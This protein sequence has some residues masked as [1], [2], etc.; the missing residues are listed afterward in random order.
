MAKKIVI[1]KKKKKQAPQRSVQREVTILGKLLRAAGSAGG[2]MLGGMMG[3]PTLGAAAGNTLGASLSRWLGSGDY[4]VQSNSIVNRTMK[5]SASVPM[6]HRTDQSV[7]IRHREFIQTVDGGTAFGIRANL[8][9][10]PGL[11]VTFPW[12]SQI[13]ANFQEYKFHGLVF[14]YVPTS[15]AATGADTRLGAVMAQTVYRATD[16]VPSTK[17]ELLN[18]FWSNESLPSEA[19]A[20]PIECKASETVLTNRYVRTGAVSDDLM[21]YD[22]G[23]TTFA[24]QGQI[25]AGLIGDLW[26]TY[27]VELRKP[28]LLSTMGQAVKSALFNNTGATMVRPMTNSATEFDSFTGGVT[29]DNPADNDLR[30]QIPRGNAGVI[31]FDITV[32]GTTLGSSGTPGYALTNCTALVNALET[33]TVPT[34]VSSLTRVTLSGCV[35]VTDPTA[36]VIIRVV[37][38][39]WSGALGR[40]VTRVTQ[41]DADV[42]GW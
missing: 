5:G 4:T 18:E 17:Y 8:P 9:L 42:V 36:A 38:Q 10:N 13:A 35:R 33:T 19:M 34:V 22:Y 7:V 27:E 39:T 15:G 3:S 32:S 26:V 31:Y 28:K 29:V 24:T 12:L 14:H 11:A 21:F 20:H 25:Q 1:Q 23:R 16:A 41:V 2:G 37:G 30:I 6:M 40:C